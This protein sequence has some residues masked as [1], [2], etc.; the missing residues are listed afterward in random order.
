MDVGGW[1]AVKGEA[2]ARGRISVV[3]MSQSSGRW[4]EVSL[5][6]T[7]SQEFSPLS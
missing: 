2:P 1:H 7:E 6:K 5:G 4:Q 3:H